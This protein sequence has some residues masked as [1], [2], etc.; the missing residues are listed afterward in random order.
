LDNNFRLQFV[1]KQCCRKSRAKLGRK[2]GPIVV[3]VGPSRP[4]RQKIGVI[5]TAMNTNLALN[6]RNQ[7]SFEQRWWRSHNGGPHYSMEEKGSCQE[8]AHSKEGKHLMLSRRSSLLH[9]FV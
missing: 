5:E 9:A 7:L 4:K 6:T 3:E 1:L 8:E 2:P